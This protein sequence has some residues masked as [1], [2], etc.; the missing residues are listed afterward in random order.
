MTIKMADLSI[1]NKFKST[2]DNIQ[3]Q[4]TNLSEELSRTIVSL[5]HEEPIKVLFNNKQIPFPE[6]FNKVSCETA[7]I[8]FAEQHKWRPV[9]LKKTLEEINVIFNIN[10]GTKLNKR[11]TK[12]LKKSQLTSYELS[13]DKLRKKFLKFGVRIGDDFRK[14]TLLELVQQKASE[15]KWR[16]NTLENNLIIINKIIDRS[17]IV[18]KSNYKPTETEY[19]DSDSDASFIEYFTSSLQNIKSN[20]TIVSNDVYVDNGED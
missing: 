16:K 12:N 17:P 15:L 3:S 19:S 6:T 2:L 9:T 20:N 18:I 5:S 7:V 1:L 14:E 4:I 11:P 10:K 8:C 13:E